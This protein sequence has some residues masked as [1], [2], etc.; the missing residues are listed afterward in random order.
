[1][2]LNPLQDVAPDERWKVTADIVSAFADIWELG[3]QTPRLPYYLRVALRLLLDTSGTTLLDIRRVQS[4]EHYRSSLLRRCTDSQ[5]VQTWR[6]FS[7]KPIKDQTIEVG[8]LQN[9]AVALADRPLPLRFVIGQST[10][11]IKIRRITDDGTPLIVELSDL[12]CAA[13]CAGHPVADPHSPN[14]F[15]FAGRAGPG[16][17]CAVAM[18]PQSII[19]TSAAVRCGSSRD[20]T[21]LGRY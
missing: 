3:P 18:I 7:A 13:R 8:S 10:S 17:G 16:A 4:E 14:V 11:T 5:A 2:G 1:M 9:K 21:C 12:S 15:A 20:V 19:A 6:E